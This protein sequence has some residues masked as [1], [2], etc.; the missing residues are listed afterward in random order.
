MKETKAYDIPSL[1]FNDLAKVSEARV[2]RITL[3]GSQFGVISF[4]EKNA[5][6]I[7][8]N[9]WSKFG[10]ESCLNVWYYSFADGITIADTCKR[11][12]GQNPCFQIA[13]GLFL[14]GIYTPGRDYWLAEEVSVRFYPDSNSNCIEFYLDSPF[15]AFLN[16]LREIT[17]DIVKDKNLPKK[18][19]WIKSPSVLVSQ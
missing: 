8:V 17:F 18:A 2:H 15:F 4:P 5:I 1:V 7:L 14:N 13:G 10:N 9:S 12:I 16:R 6:V 19:H 11:L 3:N